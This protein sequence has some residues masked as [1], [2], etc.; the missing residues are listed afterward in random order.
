MK[1]KEEFIRRGIFSGG[2]A[3]QRGGVLICNCVNDNVIG[4]KDENR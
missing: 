2:S 4:E 3:S 1:D